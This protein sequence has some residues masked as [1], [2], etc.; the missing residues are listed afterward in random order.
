MEIADSAP[1]ALDELRG[2]L[3]DSREE[4]HAPEELL[5]RLEHFFEERG[6]V[7]S[8]AMAISR[9]NLTGPGGFGEIVDDSQ[10]DA[11]RRLGNQVTQT[12]HLARSARKLGAVAAS[13]FGAGYGGS[14]WALVEEAQSQS[15]LDLWAADY[16]ESFPERSAAAQFFPSNAGPGVVQ[17]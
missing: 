4:S 16:H 7:R 1:Y 17:L 2:L 13:A 9:G 8:A 12:I 6:R 14:V 11:E 5:G 3:R 10:Q 15:F